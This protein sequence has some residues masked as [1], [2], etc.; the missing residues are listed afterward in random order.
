MSRAK[1]IAKAIEVFLTQLGQQR[2]RVRLGP[3]LNKGGAAGVVHAIEGDSTRVV[4]LYNAATLLKEG[5]SY[6]AKL[7]AMVAHP[8]LLPDPPKPPGSPVSG[9]VVQLAWPLA[10]ARDNRGKFVGFA[11]PAIEIKHTIELEYMLNDRQAQRFGLRHDLGAKLTLAHNLAAVVAG[12]HAQGH[13]IVDLKPL[14]LMFYKQDLFMAV[15]DCDGFCINMPGGTRDAPQVTPGYIAPEYTAAAITLPE[16]QDRFALA[17]IIFQLLNFGIHPYAG[18]AKRNPISS[19]Q[20]DKIAAGLYA[21]GV[22]PHTVISPVPAS[23][24][25]ALPAELRGLFD[26]AFG[27]YP[28]LRPGAA[29]WA[30]A[31]VRYA[32][33]ANRL[34]EPCTSGHLRF[35]GM[36]CGICLRESVLQAASSASATRASPNVVTQ[37]SSAIA[38]SSPASPPRPQHIRS[39]VPRQKSRWLLILGFLIPSIGW[40]MLRGTPVPREAPVVIAPPPPEIP[41]ETYLDENGKKTNAPRK[42]LQRPADAVSQPAPFENGDKANEP[43]KSL[44]RPADAVSE[45][46][47]LPPLRPTYGITISADGNDAPYVGFCSNIGLEPGSSCT[48]LESGD[49]IL[50]VEGQPVKGFQDVRAKLLGVPYMKEFVTLDVRRGRKEIQI[51]VKPSWTRR[52]QATDGTHF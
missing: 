40:V 48:G 42:S 52:L 51:R 2:E 26:R 30:G 32:T 36:T 24:H 27:S 41:H 29:E 34:L 15:L 45:P 1:V 25:E 19:E 14:N 6:E 21:Y 47:P 23:A 3:P 43:R 37:I 39:V 33:A 17:V 9:P 12:I 13:A 18:V 22:Y 44:Q 20:Q 5:A 11:M 50:A 49:V 31:L 35:S 10:I 46:A 28:S 8:P 38:S 4:K 7:E 16:Y